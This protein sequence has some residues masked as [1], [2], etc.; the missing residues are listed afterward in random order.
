MA[1]SKIK[2]VRSEK[3]YVEALARID[4]QMD[5]VPDSPELEELDA[6]LDLVE[7]YESRHEPMF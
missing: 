1:E 2:P 3:E 6:L 5:A 7:L 4:F